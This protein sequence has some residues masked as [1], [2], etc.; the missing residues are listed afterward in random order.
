VV[1]PL[2]IAMNRTLSALLVT[3]CGFAA[4]AS[5]FR[6][7]FVFDDLN[8]IVGNPAVHRIWPPWV[9]M[10]GGNNLAARP[11]PYL[12]FAIDYA[13]HGDEPF[14]YHATNLAIHLL[15]AAL[16]LRV[17][18]GTLRGPAFSAWWHDRSLAIATAVAAIWVVHPLTTQAVT[19]IYQRMESMA[20]LLIVAAVACAGAA[21]SAG[22]PAA[23]ACRRRSWQA[24][25]C[26]CGLLAALSKETAVGI[27]LLVA[28]FWWIYRSRAD[29]ETLHARLPFFIALTAATWLPLA[30]VLASG[31]GDYVELREPAHPPL[32]YLIT[33][34][35]VIV[36]YVRLAFW[37]AGQNLDYDWQVATSMGSVWW[38]L[39]TLVTAAAIT[40]RGCVARMPWSFPAV[41]FFVLLGPTSS[42]LPVADIAVEHRMYLPLAC[43]VALVIGG[44]AAA[45]E[46]TESRIATR[47]AVVAVTVIVVAFAAITHARNRVY[48]SF[49]TIWHDCHAKNP[50][51]MRANW[52]LAVEAAR[53]GDVDRA[54]ELAGRST[55][56]GTASQAFH[57][58]AKTFF[59]SGNLRASERACRE[60]MQV[61]AAHDC[62]H[63]AVWFD[64]AVL[65]TETLVSQGRLADA[66]TLSTATLPLIDRELGANHPMHFAMQTAE[67]RGRLAGPDS[68]QAV[69]EAE[70][71]DKE[72]AA[73][74][75]ADHP[76]AL[77]ATTAYAV[78]LAAVGRDGPAEQL[79]RGV[80]DLE[81]AKPLNDDRKA[82]A[83]ATLANFL[84]SRGRKAEA[85]A[86]RGVLGR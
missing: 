80:V 56:A 13:L 11:L 43:I 12:S 64:L 17:V 23:S 25:A 71:L 74:L 78:A 33:Q 36:H 6:G 73:A 16:L 69:I 19:Y 10:L 53:Q 72:A 22:L 55:E 81:M 59:E 84:A 68:P 14:G 8:E 15:C 32:Q 79:L 66:Q 37:P 28:A 52:H 42:V 85:D 24:T 39:V 31:R 40:I 54:V 3:L 67:L 86:L 45:C 21:F 26:C 62:L 9:P 49:S 5:S 70:Q 65:L 48:E 58:C 2:R 77:T 1:L 75:G 47:W 60:G 82:A 57:Q 61:F 76:V 4:Y 35:E 51:G 83:L 7:A 50:R 38:Q 63:K 44:V 29:G 41:A 18:D 27:P 34:A 20:A 30:A 46:R